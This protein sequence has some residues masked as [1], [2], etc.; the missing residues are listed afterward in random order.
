M[1]FFCSGKFYKSTFEKC[2]FFNNFLTNYS[3]PTVFNPINKN[4]NS[5]N[6]RFKIKNFFIRE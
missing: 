1:I 2:G 5:I 4:R 3:I 6:L